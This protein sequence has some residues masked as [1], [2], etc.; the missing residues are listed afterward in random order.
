VSGSNAVVTLQSCV[1][2]NH[3]AIGGSG[4]GYY[5]PPFAVDIEV[6]GA[7]AAGA[8]IFLSGGSLNLKDCIVRNCL[9]HLHFHC[10]PGVC[11]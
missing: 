11:R 1:L 5:P 2:S 3:V 8:A 6:A 9:A 7:P 10:S 4:S